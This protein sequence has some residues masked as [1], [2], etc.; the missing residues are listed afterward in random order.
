MLGVTGGV[1]GSTLGESVAAE[2]TV[3]W[4]LL[5]WIVARRAT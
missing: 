5:I 2:V 4:I 1:G 3:N